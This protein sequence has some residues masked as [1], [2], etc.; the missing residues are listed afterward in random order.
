MLMIMNVLNDISSDTLILQIV[1]KQ[2]LQKLKKILPKKPDFKD[3]I[4]STK[5]KNRI[6]SALVFLL[7]KIRKNI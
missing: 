2:E 3:I 4:A 6:P 7:T 5:L 1:T